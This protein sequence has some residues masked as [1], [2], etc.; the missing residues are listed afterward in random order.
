MIEG[1]PAMIKVDTLHLFF[2]SDNYPE[3]HLKRYIF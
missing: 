1:E 3:T 2:W